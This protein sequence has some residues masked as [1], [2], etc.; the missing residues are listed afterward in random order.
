VHDSAA[1]PP[2][3]R[4]A[5]NEVSR[6]RADSALRA[7]ARGAPSR[8]AGAA[9]NT[10]ARDVPPGRVVPT[11]TLAAPSRADSS[12]GERAARPAPGESAS[13]AQATLPVTPPVS[14]APPPVSPPVSQPAPR[15]VTPAPD[16]AVE[17]G[18]LVDAY[19]RAIQSRDLATLRRLYPAMTAEQQQGFRDFFSYTRSLKASLDVESLRVD[20]LSAEA[21]L[22]GLY[23]F[24]TTAG[25]EQRQPVSFQVTLRRESGGWRFASMR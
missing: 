7:A 16:P 20:G 8:D 13:R 17:I 15:S 11:P 5:A 6:P 24:V 18:A 4:A 12:I 2:Q 1:L 19:A 9:R 22:A 23:E 3:R 21:R 25:R 10:P 14:A